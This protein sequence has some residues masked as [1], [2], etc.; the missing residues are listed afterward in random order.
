ML[1]IKGAHGNIIEDGIVDKSFGIQIEN[2][3]TCTAC[4]KISANTVVEKELNLAVPGGRHKIPKL[5]ETLFNPEI[6]RSDCETPRY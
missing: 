3:I 2:V 1:S 4:N 6:V 5:L